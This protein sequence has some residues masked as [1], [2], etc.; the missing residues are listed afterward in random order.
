MAFLCFSFGRSA[1]RL[2]GSILM[3]QRFNTI[4]SAIKKVENLAQLKGEDV[5]KISS[6]ELVAR[7]E[8]YLKQVQDD[9]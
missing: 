3:A 7:A 2:E 6:E 1:G 5:S 9:E 4:I 8:K